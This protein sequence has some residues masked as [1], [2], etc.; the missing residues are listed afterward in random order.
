MSLWISFAQHPAHPPAVRN[1]E[2][3]V[4]AW[5]FKSLVQ[6]RAG[7]HTQMRMQASECLNPGPAS[8]S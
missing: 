4:A 1:D 2:V 8:I 6:D 5:R 3:Q 7:N